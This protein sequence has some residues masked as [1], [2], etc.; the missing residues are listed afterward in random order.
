MMRGKGLG[1]WG[2]K[3]TAETRTY[4]SLPLT[5]TYLTAFRAFQGYVHFA[6]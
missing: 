5:S 1:K 6:K 2:K 4:L 3:T